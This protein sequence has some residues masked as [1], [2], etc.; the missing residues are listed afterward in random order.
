MYCIL[1]KVFVKNMQIF[2]YIVFALSVLGNFSFDRNV[3]HQFSIL[4]YV[5][6]KIDH[7][8]SR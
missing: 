1:L 5:K 6:I 2:S 4:G 7:G 3:W 8:L